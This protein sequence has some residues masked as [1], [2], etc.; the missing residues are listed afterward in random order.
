MPNKRWVS[1]TQ[2][3]ATFRVY[4]GRN[5][6]GTC[7]GILVEEVEE[8]RIVLDGAAERRRWRIV[9]LKGPSL[10][11]PTESPRDQLVEIELADGRRGSGL[12]R[13]STMTGA[14]PLA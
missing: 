3:A 10:H 14:G 4:A 12:V 5:S 13:G 2:L 1:E 6:D 8:T 7:T 9:D 11:H